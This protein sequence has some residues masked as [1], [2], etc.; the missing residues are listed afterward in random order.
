MKTLPLE[1]SI[2]ERKVAPQRA[3]IPPGIARRLRIFLST[4]SA[5]QCEAPEAKVVPISAMCTATEATD[6]VAPRVSRSVELE[7]P[8]PIPKEPSISC[9]IDPASANNIQFIGLI[10]IVP[11]HFQQ[12]KVCRLKQYLDLLELHIPVQGRSS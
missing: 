3:P 9:A 8:N 6:A 2:K 10:S 7:R 5:C 1:E 12:L 4:F 11:G